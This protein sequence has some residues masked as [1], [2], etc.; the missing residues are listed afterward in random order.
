MASSQ[1]QTEENETL[2]NDDFYKDEIKKRK[3]MIIINFMK[4]ENQIKKMKAF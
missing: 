1:V 4:G 2:V 3:I